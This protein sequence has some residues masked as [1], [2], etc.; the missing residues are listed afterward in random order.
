MLRKK[1]LTEIFAVAS[2]PIDGFKLFQDICRQYEKRKLK[3]QGALAKDL[4]GKPTFRPVYIRCLHGL[5]AVD[6][7]QLLDKV[8]EFNIVFVQLSLL[9]NVKEEFF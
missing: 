4:K 5:D 6:R 2:L 8:S 1:A 3:D 9:P 7:V